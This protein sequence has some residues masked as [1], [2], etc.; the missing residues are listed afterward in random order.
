MTRQEVREWIQVLLM[1]AAV[2]FAGYW[3]AKS[4][5]TRETNAKSVRMAIDVLSHDSTHSDRVWAAKV[6]ARFS[7]VPFTAEAESILVQ[8]GQ[9]MFG[10]GLFAEVVGRQFNRLLVC[11]SVGHKCRPM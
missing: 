5:A 6:L 11:D 8:V 4:N 7:E 2:A 10:Q 3:V 9:G 1:P